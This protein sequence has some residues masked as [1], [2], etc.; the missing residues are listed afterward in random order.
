MRHVA[1]LC[2]WGETYDNIYCSEKKERIK[3]S[4]S[5]FLS[6]IIPNLVKASEQSERIEM[7]KEGIK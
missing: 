4:F 3:P 5:P 2:K 6:L 7:T 1:P